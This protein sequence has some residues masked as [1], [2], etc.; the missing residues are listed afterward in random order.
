MN[1]D[2]GGFLVV[3][4]YQLAVYMSK[5]YPTMVAIHSIAVV[6][7]FPV[8]AKMEAATATRTNAY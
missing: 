3:L 8:T 5:A 7:R 4:V 1:P 2:G 6:P